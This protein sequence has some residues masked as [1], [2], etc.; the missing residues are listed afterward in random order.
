VSMLNRIVIIS[1]S[2]NN[3]C[4]RS[5]NFDLVVCSRI[6]ETV[7]LPY[8]EQNTKTIYGL[9]GN[10]LEIQHTSTRMHLF[11]YMSFSLSG[12]AWTPT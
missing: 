1:N 7:V 11:F 3:Y 5:F 10:L 12:S 4:K 8:Q 6:E 9:E 2:I